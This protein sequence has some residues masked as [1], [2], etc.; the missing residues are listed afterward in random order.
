MIIDPTK[1]TITDLD[2]YVSA[3][4]LEDWTHTMSQGIDLSSFITP[5]VPFAAPVSPVLVTALPKCQSGM[6]DLGLYNVAVLVTDPTIYSIIGRTPAGDLLAVEIPRANVTRT[7]ALA[8]GLL[9]FVQRI[10]DGVYEDPSEIDPAAHSAQD[11]ADA[12]LAQGLVHTVPSDADAEY[13]TE[14]IQSVVSTSDPLSADTIADLQALV[15]EPT[16]S[17]DGIIEADY[18]M[19]D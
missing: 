6:T 16:V 5:D 10:R 3:T 11:L 2:T 12:V 15:A 9:Q 4:D 17:I 1:Y 13:L 8:L 18:S 19:V 7:A 14:V